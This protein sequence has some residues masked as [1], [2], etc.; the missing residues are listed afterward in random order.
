[1]K[2]QIKD[3][4]AQRL[5]RLCNVVY[6]ITTCDLFCLVLMVVNTL[7]SQSAVSGIDTRRGLSCRMAQRLSTVAKHCGKSTMTRH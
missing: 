1:M 2:S 4:M 7:L 3:I 6:L 5:S